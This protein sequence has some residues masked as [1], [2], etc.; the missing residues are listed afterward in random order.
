MTTIS[1]ESLETNALKF[2][3]IAVAPLIFVAWLFLHD[4]L[5]QSSDPKIAGL[6]KLTPS[7]RQQRL[8]EGARGEG[9]AIIYANMDVAAMNP[10]VQGFMKNTLP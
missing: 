3:S 1:R 6:E 9:E 8:L 5:A 4:A 2:S 10:L 7:E